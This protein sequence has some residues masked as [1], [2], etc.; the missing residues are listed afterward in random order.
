MNKSILVLGGNGFIGKN[1]FNNLIKYGYNCKKLVR[2][3]SF[4]FNSD[5]IYYYEKS[6]KI[7]FSD[8]IN[9]FDYFINCIGNH[10][11]IKYFEYI[12]NY[13]IRKI[14][15]KIIDKNI[16]K[17]TF[18]QISSLSVYGNTF[19]IKNIIINEETLEKPLNEYGKSKLDID[20]YLIEKNKN[21]N[22][23]NY[24]ILRVPLVYSDKYYPKFLISI[25]KIIK[26]YLFIYLIDKNACFSLIHINDLGNIIN[27]LIQKKVINQIYI[28]ANNQK[29]KNLVY[30]KFFIF[31]NLV[32]HFNIIMLIK[33][34]L[35]YFKFNSYYLDVL[36]NKT[37]FSC[38]KL[39]N[40]FEKKY[41]FTH[42][43]ID[44]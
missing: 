30:K 2:K 5:E 39:N 44:E 42:F 36:T 27:L 10:R 6:N 15:K 7:Y 21:N 12:N 32:I 18:I 16:K 24:L 23:F 4:T 35:I 34:I 25:K 3:K 38:K 40:L 8:K 20:N 41:S 29:L 19:S 31:N 26:Y 11:N 9:K 28:T 1:I 17:I 14:I 13:L 43:K 22:K 33:K 37:K